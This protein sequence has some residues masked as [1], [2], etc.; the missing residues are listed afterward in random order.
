MIRIM[1]G[2]LVQVGRNRISVEDFSRIIAVKDRCQAGPT[3]PANGLTLMEITYPDMP[4]SS[5][6]GKI[7][8]RNN[9]G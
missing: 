4:G 6:P 3:A 9:A 2:T 1:T 8:P 5:L 7:P